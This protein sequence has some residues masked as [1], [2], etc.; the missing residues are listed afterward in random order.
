MGSAHAQESEIRHLLSI[1]RSG[2]RKMKN[3][4]A[5]EKRLRTEERIQTRVT[6]MMAVIIGTFAL[7]WFPFATMFILAPVWPGFTR[8]MEDHLVL[9]DVLT[10]VGYIN[11]AVNPVIC[12]AMNTDIRRGMARFICPRAAAASA[13]LRVPR[14]PRHLQN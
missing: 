4:T 7:T 9:A 1:Q 10:W 14:G 3:L 12:A 6:W 8:Y 5:A 2:T 13:S 11:S